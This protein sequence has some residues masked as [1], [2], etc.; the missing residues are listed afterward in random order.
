V[1]KRKVMGMVVFRMLIATILG[2]LLIQ[3][4]TWPL[5]GDWR[6]E[7]GGGAGAGAGHARDGT[8]TGSH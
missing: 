6:G 1:P 4:S 5:E 3:C 8:R 7:A 2:V